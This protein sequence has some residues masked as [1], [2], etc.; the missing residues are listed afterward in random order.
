[1]VFVLRKLLGDSLN[2]LTRDGLIG[3]G[4]YSVPVFNGFFADGLSGHS[5][6]PYNSML[7]D[8]LHQSPSYSTTGILQTTPPSRSKIFS[9]QGTTNLKD[10]PAAVGRNSDTDSNNRTLP[11]SKLELPILATQISGTST[12]P[13]KVGDVAQLASGTFSNP[14]DDPF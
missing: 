10:S 8:I 9:N 12:D 13:D 14:L 7:A 6:Y 4:P 5:G 2:A 11:P 3:P 1:M